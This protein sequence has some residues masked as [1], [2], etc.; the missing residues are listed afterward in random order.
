MGSVQHTDR[1][2]VDTWNSARLGAGAIACSS[3]TNVTPVGD[4]GA[5]LVDA[6]ERGVEKFC[7]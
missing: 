7:A 5:V 3:G 1:S 6:L 2:I 4:S